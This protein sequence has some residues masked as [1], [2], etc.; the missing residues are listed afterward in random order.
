MQKQR[1]ITT[2]FKSSEVKEADG[3]LSK[4]KHLPEVICTAVWSYL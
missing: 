3:T 4:C 1:E 2:I